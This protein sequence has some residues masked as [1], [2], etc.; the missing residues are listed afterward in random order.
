MS[1]KATSVMAEACSVSNLPGPTEECPCHDFLTLF[2]V[3]HILFGVQLFMLAADHFPFPFGM[4]H[5]LCVVSSVTA[6]S[7]SVSH[8]DE[9]QM[10]SFCGLAAL[11][12]IQLY[13]M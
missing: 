12:T 13:R 3:G 2:L 7:H 5:L 8:Y 6:V 4:T 9:I 11:L 10:E 1:V